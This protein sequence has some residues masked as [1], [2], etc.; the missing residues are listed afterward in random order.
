MF[1]IPAALSRPASKAQFHRAA[2]ALLR[3]IAAD[4]GH[5]GCDITV[6]SATPTSTMG[7]ITMITPS[8][9]IEVFME[10][11]GPRETPRLM[12]RDR[13]GNQPARF[14]WLNDMDAS[15]RANVLS[16]M[17]LI[18]RTARPGAKVDAAGKG[19]VNRI[20]SLFA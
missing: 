3:A 9:S 13:F 12:F 8:L 6:G 5:E 16:E 2:E 18:A 20:T 17:K 15:S 11:F 1:Q 4:L 14:K 7:T 19:L 10:G